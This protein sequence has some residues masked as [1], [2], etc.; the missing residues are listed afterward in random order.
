MRGRMVRC[1]RELWGEGPAR[2]DL[3]VDGLRFVVQSTD[4]A[5]TSAKHRGSQ[6]E[7]IVDSIE[8]AP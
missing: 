4:Y 2:V 8:I 5:G 3:D 7:A 6:L 1:P